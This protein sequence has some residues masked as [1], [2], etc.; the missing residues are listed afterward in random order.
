VQGVP[1]WVPHERLLG[2]GEWAPDADGAWTLQ[3]DREAAADVQARL[4]G[5]GMDG[6][7]LQVQVIPPLKRAY[8]REARTVDARRRRD[9]SPGFTRAGV[10]LDEEA[11]YSLTPEALASALGKRA[12]GLRV[13]DATC[14]G[15]GNTIGFARAGCD[16]IAIER[17]EAR[18]AS[19]R[20]NASLYGVSDRIRFIAGDAAEHL[21]TLDADLCFVDPP[22]EA[23]DPV[24]CPLD[25]LPVLQHLLPHT[26]RFGRCWL[27]LPPSFVTADLP[28]YSPSA[29]FGVATGD[30]SRVKF[31]LLDRGQRP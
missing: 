12:R 11:R 8:V 5:L 13:V 20:H 17:D 9:T 2:P 14:G 1:A 16:V 7:A 30:Q 25:A 24:R 23:P 10:R 6:T 28:D 26:A 15:G 21:H 29:W 18:L 31:L 3:C 19:A 22:W 4:R 27:K